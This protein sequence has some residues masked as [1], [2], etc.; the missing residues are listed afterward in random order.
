MRR[1]WVRP[2][3]LTYSMSGRRARPDSCRREFGDI[4]HLLYLDESG[5]VAD[6]A[7]KHYV[8]AGVCAFERKTHWIEQCFNAAPLVP[9]CGKCNQSKGN[10]EWKT[11]MLSTAKLSPTARGTKDILER[12]KRM[13]AYEN[14]KAP[15]KIDFAAICC[16]C[17]PNVWGQRQNK[18]ER[19]QSLMRES[20]AL[21]ARINTESP[22][23]AK[24]SSRAV[25]RHSQ[26]AALSGSLRASRSGCS[27]LLR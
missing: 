6:P 24:C 2:A 17:W 18:L 8:L 22:M 19:M 25:E 26:K 21:A 1:V 15:T 10:K 5:S 12:I 23:H 27:S 7:Q 11:W 14:F 16:H 13:E 9:S 20:R 4:V 3:W